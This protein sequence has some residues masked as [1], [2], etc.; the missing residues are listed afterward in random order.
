MENKTLSLREKLYVDIAK[1]LLGIKIG[2]KPKIS[3]IDLWNNQ[4]AHL[5]E[6][7]VIS[8]PCAFIEFNSIK[9]R[10]LGRH[11]QQGEV[12]VNLHVGSKVIVSSGM[13]TG[14]NYAATE[15]LRLLDDIHLRIKSL[16]LDYGGSFTRI[17]SSTDHDHDNIIAHMEQ[18]RV[19]VLDRSAEPVRV[20][21]KINKVTE[22][23]EK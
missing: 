17:S 5:A 18:Y 15:H 19:V 12:L 2:G 3:Y 6:E 22:A 8:F 23:N 20:S 7:R 11:V 16:R 4:W 21:R 10:Q 9:W 14:F 13:S 1:H